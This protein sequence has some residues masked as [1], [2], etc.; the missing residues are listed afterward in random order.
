MRYK[1]VVRD[2]GAFQ[3]S[4]TAAQV[5]A[6]TARAFGPG[7]VATEAV[8]LGG[9]MFNTTLRVD[10]RGFPGPVIVR[11]APRPEAQARSE[12]DLLRTE[13]AAAPFLATIAPLLP[14]TLFADFTRQVLPRDFLVQTVLPG[15]P[16]PEGLAAWPKQEWPAFY[17]QLGEITKTV[18]AIAAEGS[19]FGRPGMSEAST[20]STA[21][22]SELTLIA[23]DLD[24]VDMDA[25]DLRQV[26]DLCTAHAD[27]LDQITRPRLTL[28]DLWVPN[29][30][31]DPAAASPTICGVFDTDRALWGD[32]A[33]D[34]TNFQVALKPGTPAE[35]FWDT[36]GRPA[37][38]VDAQWRAAA[39]QVRHWGAIRLERQRRGLADRLPATYEAV[40]A[41]L[42][43][44][45]AR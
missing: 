10:G 31:V 32:P 36:Y 42:P 27:V 40:A 44:L 28:G 3:E 33:A 22:V 12:R 43:V 21:I 2:S 18:H 8:E 11:V 25:S 5:E 13:H 34:W 4:V 17:R 24:Q 38:D 6:M 37:G 20:W 26:I 29:V 23:D 35:A 1:P 14:R 30:M 15:V 16:A 39:Y 7:V 19:R 41:L 45:T 9:G